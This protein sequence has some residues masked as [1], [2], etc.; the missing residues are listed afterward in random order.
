MIDIV[1]NH[2]SR[3]SKWFNNFKRNK[4]LGYNFYFSLNKR[5]NTSKVVRARSH[6]LLQKIDTDKGIRYVWCTF[7]PDQI[8]FDYRNPEV[9]L[10]FL[11]II[12]FISIKGPQIF[13]L[14][15]V[16]FLWK[17][18]GSNCINLDQTHAIVRLIRTFLEKI[19][20]NSLNSKQKLTCLFMKTYLILVTL[21]K[22]ILYIIFL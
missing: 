12:K 3:K 8:D 16:A 10:M 17:R 6:K 1:L 5:I 7:S 11:K 15:A 18:V 4:G 2:G 22:H 19:S 14:D 20:P 9:L 13:R 21:M